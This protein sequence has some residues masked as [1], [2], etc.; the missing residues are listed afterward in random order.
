MTMIGTVR[1]TSAWRTQPL[2][3]LDAVEATGQNGRSSRIASGGCV[4]AAVDAFCTGRDRFDLVSPRPPTSASII[5]CR[6]GSRVFDDENA[7]GAP[8]GA[9]QHSARSSARKGNDRARIPPRRARD[10]PGRRASAQGSASPSSSLAPC[11]PAISATAKRATLLGR[12]KVPGSTSS[13]SRARR[14]DAGR[15]GPA[16]STMMRGPRPPASGASAWTSVTMTPEPRGVAAIAVGG[17][18]LVAGWRSAF[19]ATRTVTGGPGSLP[20]ARILDL[21]PSAAGAGFRGLAVRRSPAQEGLTSLGHARGGRS[22]R[23]S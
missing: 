1:V 8:E 5:M 2:A 6:V 4:R 15:I 20:G 16:S 9:P 11:A 14:A 13:A 19:G 23:W 17:E 12:P 7:H 18:A 22:L 21:D 3:D 10:L